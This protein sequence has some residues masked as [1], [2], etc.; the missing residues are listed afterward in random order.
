MPQE[1]VDMHEVMLGA[2]HDIETFFQERNINMDGAQL[3]CS[4]YDQDFDKTFFI[5]VGTG[6]EFLRRGMVQSWLNTVS[7]TEREKV[8]EN[9]FNNIE[10]G[11]DEGEEDEYPNHI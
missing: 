6:N 3:L 8:R 9:F 2:L 7:E 10:E 1:H 5:G 11:F 4:F